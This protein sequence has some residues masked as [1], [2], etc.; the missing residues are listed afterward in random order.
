MGSA[1]VGEDEAFEAP[2]VFEDVV[3]EVLVFAGP[4]AVDLVVG[5]HDGGCVGD[6]EADFEGE[7]IGL[8]HGA[9][10]EDGVDDVAAGLLV[11]EGV[12]LDVADHVLG[13]HALHE[14]ADH[15]SGED[16]VFALVFEVAAVAGF[17]GDVD[18]STEGHVV[19]LVAEFFADEGSVS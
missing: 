4:V 13:L 14:L 3:E 15:G 8:A 7:E 5:A 18:A 11:V 10:V 6:V 17:A 16:G 1:P 19:A 2:G 12:V 9:L